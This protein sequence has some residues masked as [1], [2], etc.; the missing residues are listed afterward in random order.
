MTPTAPKPDSTAGLG[1]FKGTSGP[2]TDPGSSIARRG[3]GPASGVVWVGTLAEV[4]EAAI[5]P[6]RCIYIIWDEP[7]WA[8][9]IRPVYVGAAVSEDS[10]RRFIHHLTNPASEP[11]HRLARGLQVDW[12]SWPLWVLEGW[13][14]NT[15]AAKLGYR[16]PITVYRVER[17]AQKL[18]KPKIY[19]AASDAD[20]PQAYTPPFPLMRRRRI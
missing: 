13:G 9:G 11:R 4:L 7:K 6:A 8:K 18:L 19:G 1:W 10:K 14:P 16:K 12:E 3:V 17:Y 5:T 20:Q 15:L 2:G